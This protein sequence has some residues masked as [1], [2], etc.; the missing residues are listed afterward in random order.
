MYKGIIIDKINEKTG[1]QKNSKY[2]VYINEIKTFL[3]VNTDKELEIYK[4][5]HFKIHLFYDEIRLLDKIKIS[6]VDI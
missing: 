2:L 6:Y 4:E 3:N 5:Y 1:E